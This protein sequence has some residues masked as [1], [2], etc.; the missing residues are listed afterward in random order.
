MYSQ[1]LE[2]AIILSSNYRY[3][4]DTR[5]NTVFDSNLYRT[6]PYQEIRD[7]QNTGILVNVREWLLIQLGVSPRGAKTFTIPKDYYTGFRGVNIMGIVFWIKS[8]ESVA[9][10]RGKSSAHRV[11]CECPECGRSI[12]VGRMHQHAVVHR[13]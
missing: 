7:L 6:M 5:T 8:S 3:Y 10:G 1:I 2:L 9:K 11:F 12:P 4:I 13:S